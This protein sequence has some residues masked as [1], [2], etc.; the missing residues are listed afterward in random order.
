MS[1]RITSGVKE[2]QQLVA[3]VDFIYQTLPVWRDDPERPN[4]DRE[5]DLNETLYIVLA[6]RAKTKMPLFL[7][8]P[9]ARASGQRRIDMA[10]M[11]SEKIVLAARTYTKY[12]TVLAIECKRLPAPTRDR[13]REYVSGGDKTTGGIQRFKLSEHGAG[14]PVAV[15]VGYIQRETAQIWLEKINGWLVE[16]AGSKTGDGLLWESGEKLGD[17]RYDGEAATACAISS[18]PRISGTPR[19]HEQPIEIRHL[20]VEMSRRGAVPI[21]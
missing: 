1:G 10:V 6:N 15:M 8:T 16:M 12:E 7:F 13:E 4:A 19:L 14:L 9:E 17:F 21:S 2:N 11:S 3:L 5:T 18:H 20:W